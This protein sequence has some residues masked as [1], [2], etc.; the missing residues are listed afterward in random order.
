M[1]SYGSG[2]RG[3]TYRKGGK[4]QK[5]KGQ[6]EKEKKGKGAEEDQTIENRETIESERQGRR[7]MQRICKRREEHQH[8]NKDQKERMIRKKKVL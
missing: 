7:I 2:R 1:R 3:A 8:K 6:E 4:G 5:Q